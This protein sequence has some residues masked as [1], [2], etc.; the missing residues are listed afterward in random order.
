MVT[1]IG[2]RKTECVGGSGIFHRIVHGR[3]RTQH[4]GVGQSELQK[5]PGERKE[6]MGREFV[7]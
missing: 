3:G 6:L 1:T 5:V 7:E 4:T 2:E